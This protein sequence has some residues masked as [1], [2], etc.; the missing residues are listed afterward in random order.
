M[1]I[2]KH[3]CD[4]CGAIKEQEASTCPTGWYVITVIGTN[5][6]KEMRQGVLQICSPACGHK[7]LVDV[8]N[9]LFA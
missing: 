6:T 2:F 7:A 8:V 4:G 3:V 9:K 5:H 1:L